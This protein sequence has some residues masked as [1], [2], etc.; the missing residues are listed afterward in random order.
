[1]SE[2]SGAS[3]QRGG[4]VVRKD[5]AWPVISL[6]RGG[7]RKHVLRIRATRINPT[8]GS[9]TVMRGTESERD[10]ERKTMVGRQRNGFMEVSDIKLAL[11][12]QTRQ[13]TLLCNDGVAII[14]RSRRR[15]DISAINVLVQ[16]QLSAAM[17]MSKMMTERDCIRR[18]GSVSL[19]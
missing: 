13:H 18:D 11:R 16:G 10:R 15:V 17:P 2:S 6:T 3:S 1:M 14:A 8:R 12:Y 5:S 7:T 4:N 19:P 9:S